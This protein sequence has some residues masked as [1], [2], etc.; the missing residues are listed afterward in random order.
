MCNARSVRHELNGFDLS[1]KEIT[2]SNRHFA[3]AWSPPVQVELIRKQ[4]IAHRTFHRWKAKFGRMEVSEAKRLREVEAEN[5]RLERLLSD[6]MLERHAIE[7][8]LH[9]QW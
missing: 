3:G 5:A 6:A 9:R 2:T 7:E 8:A 4:G 1:R